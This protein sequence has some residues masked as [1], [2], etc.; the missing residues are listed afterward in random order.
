MDEQALA[1]MLRDAGGELILDVDEDDDDDDDVDVDVAINETTPSAQKENGNGAVNQKEYKNSI[2][3]EDK[4][5]ES[6]QGIRDTARLVDAET[7]RVSPC[8]CLIRQRTTPLGSTSSSFSSSSS[9]IQHV[10]ELISSR[11]VIEVRVAIVGNVD[12]GKSTLVGCLTRCL[13]DDGRGLARSKIFRHA[14]EAESGRTSSVAQHTLCIDAGGKTLNTEG[15]RAGAERD[16]VG[17]AS[18]VITLVDLAGHEKYFKTTAYGLTGY[19]PDYACVLVGA[20]AGIT[21]MCKEHLGVALALKVP[22]FF[23]ITKIDIAPEHILQKTV[24][25]IHSILRKPSVKKKPFLCKNV[26][27]VVAGA[28]ALPGGGVAPIFLTS[29]VT[30]DGLDLVRLMYNLLPQRHKWFERV[31]LP[32]EFIVDDVFGVPGVGTVVSGTVTRGTISIAPSAQTALV[33]GPSIGDASFKQTSVKSIQYKRLPV[34]CVKAGQTAAFALKKVKRN[35]VRKGMVLLHDDKS[36]PPKATWEFDADIAILTH[37]TTIQP[38]YQAVI[39]CEIVKQAAKVIKMN[40]EQLRSGDRA[41]V[42]FRFL[43]R[44]EYLKKGSRFVFREGKTKGIGLVVNCHGLGFAD[45]A[46]DNSEI[47]RPT[48]IAQ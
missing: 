26:H 39:H 38:K 11:S 7:S 3:N 27:D 48:L 34:E 17:R 1:T 5:R 20:N 21:G 41:S 22:V 25:Q 30:G 29:S 19:L 13:L 4:K 6:F 44:P 24:N 43:M 15:Q 12:S 16:M 47:S 23:V 37:S 42:R 35:A 40:K 10:K 18:K 36:M 9:T 32:A 31:N 28:R 45:D 14:H 8:H 2:H 33:L 46:Q